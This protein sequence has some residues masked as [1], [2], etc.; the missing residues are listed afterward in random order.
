MKT[1]QYAVKTSLQK[2][3]NVKMA[4]F[5]AA[6]LI[7]S[8]TYD[9]PYLQ[10]VREKDYPISWCIFPFQMTSHFILTIFYFG[11][12]YINSDAPFLQHV[13][14]YQVIRTGR[15][16]WAAGQ[17]GGILIRAFLA[18]LTMAVA[19][20][21]PF[22]GRIEFSGEWGKVVKSLASQRGED[23]YGFGLGQRLEFRF[24]YEILNEFTPVQLMLITVLICTLICT[25]LGVWMFLAGLYAGKV[26]A[27][28]TALAWVA[29]LFIVENIHGLWK[30]RAAHFV[31]TY[32]AEVALLNT[33]ESGNYR[34]P[35]LAYMFA[36]LGIAILVM[37]ALAYRKIRHMEFNW[38]NEDA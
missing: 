12:I 16:R 32:W 27:V 28:A 14:M 33:L 21:L 6:I 24:F 5:C 26:V 23:G 2:I 30:L 35:S 10:F 17:I 18:V 3:L 31:P 8:W 11:I 36:V 38:E 37:S 15:G 20:V 34:L 7:L 19:A 9:Q 25:F 1:L 13:N 4:I 22:A 29:A